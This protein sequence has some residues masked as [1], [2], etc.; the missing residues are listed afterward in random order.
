MKEEILSRLDVFAAKLGVGVEHLWEIY[1]MQAHVAGWYHLI[2]LLVGTL[3]FYLGMRT[4]VEVYW[5]KEDCWTS[6]PTLEGIK[7]ISFT[8]IGAWIFLYNIYRVIT[9]FINPEYYAFNKLL[10]IIT[11]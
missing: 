5:E 1:V 3:L 9:Y 6:Y 8:V 2:L 11:Q 7:M 4:K 10:N